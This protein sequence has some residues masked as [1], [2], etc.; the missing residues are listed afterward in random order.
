MLCTIFGLCVYLLQSTVSCLY[1]KWNSYRKKNSMN[2]SNPMER[3]SYVYTIYV[4]LL[5]VQNNVF[6]FRTS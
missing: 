4:Y 5:Y 6:Q 3:H 2:S 1:T